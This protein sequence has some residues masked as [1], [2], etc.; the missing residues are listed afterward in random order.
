LPATAATGP[1]WYALH[2]QSHCE[3]LVYQQLAARGFEAFLPKVDAWSRRAG[4]RRLVR[5]PMFPG[6][7]FL[8]HV[9]DKASHVEVRKARGLVRILGDRWDRLAAVPDGEV[10]AVRRL[11]GSD[12]P[13]L[14]HPYLREGCRVRITRG[15]LADVEGILLRTNPAR[16]LVVL[17]L[18]LL[19]RSVA[20]EI[21]C[22]Q[23]APA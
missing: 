21:D 20:V 11:A 5:V 6:Y 16:G 12:V 17:S 23:V 7:L 2:T 13:A 10:E 9:M 18:H 22:T 3:D 15:P 4:A 14:P 8:H 1:G 19:Q